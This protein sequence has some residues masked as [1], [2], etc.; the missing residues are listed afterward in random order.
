MLHV[1]YVKGLGGPYAIISMERDTAIQN[2]PAIEPFTEEEY[3]SAIAE[4]VGK[5]PCGGQFSMTAPVRCPKC[6]S[7]AVEDDGTFSLDYD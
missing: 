4:L 2:D 7:T 6:R 5:C 1:R 3:Y